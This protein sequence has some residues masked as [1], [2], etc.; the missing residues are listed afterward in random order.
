MSFA[1]LS[2]CCSFFHTLRR[3]NNQMERTLAPRSQQHATC[4]SAAA[5]WPEAGAHQCRGYDAGW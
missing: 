3:R 2:R 1:I 4:R 5:C